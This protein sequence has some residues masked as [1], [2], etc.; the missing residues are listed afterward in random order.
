MVLG[1]S[2][3]GG[4]TKEPKIINSLNPKSPP[5]FS[6]E[7]ASRMVRKSNGGKHL[8][9]LSFGLSSSD[10]ISTISF[11][12]RMVQTRVMYIMQRLQP[13]DFKHIYNFYHEC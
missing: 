12:A 4:I 10:E 7:M 5:K 8:M 3:I 6:F 11:R 13:V 2:R 9:V 1:W